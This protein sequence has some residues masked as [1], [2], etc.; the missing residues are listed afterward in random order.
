MIKT[1]STRNFFY[2]PAFLALLFLAIGSHALHPHYHDEISTHS[3]CG[4]E[5][6]ESENYSHEVAVGI[7]TPGDHHSCT[8]CEFLAIYSALNT[9]TVQLFVRLYPVERA[10]TFNQLSLISNYWAGLHIR[11]PPSYSPITSD[12]NT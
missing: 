9:A 5:H 11:G 10:V 4:F 8:I 1:I 7:S 3:D 12:N 6:A 2:F